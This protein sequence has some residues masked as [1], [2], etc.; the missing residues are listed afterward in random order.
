[1]PDLIKDNLTYKTTL[2]SEADEVIIGGK[3]PL[4]FKPE[5]TFTKWNKENSLTIKPLFDIPNA[6]TSLV[7]NK[8]EYKGD[9]IGWY[10]NPDPD[11]SENLKFGLILY[12][13]P[14]TNVFQFQLEGWE[15]FNFFYQYTPLHDITL[16]P[17]ILISE[18]VDFWYFKKESIA[19]KYWKSFAVYH[20]TK[21]NY[22]IGQTNYMCGKMG[23]ILVPIFKDLNGTTS[24][25]ILTIQNGIY[26]I[27]VN[28]KFLDNAV[29]PVVA[30]DTFGYLTAPTYGNDAG[31][32]NYIVYNDA[33]TVPSGNGTLTSITA[34][35]DGNG[36]STYTA[37]AAL[38][39][40]SVNTQTLVANSSTGE[41]AVPA[42]VGS[43]TTRNTSAATVDSTKT[44]SLAVCPHY[45]GVRTWY[46][47]GSNYAGWK[48]YDFN[49]FPPAT[50]TSTDDR[51]YIWGIYATYTPAGG[52]VPGAG[53]TQHKFIMVS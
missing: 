48:Y 39:T 38:F 50:F 5:I 35:V 31:D 20:K 26:T 23:N 28:Q 4:I 30:N 42:S 44:N 32:S 52:A 21:K 43:G 6:T 11:N 10:A 53:D 1:M 29:Y 41:F 34:Y 45:D 27:I 49:E 2:G 22:V 40:R 3:N 46:D 18:D 33:N 37:K 7:G 19:K 13:K 15:E 16:H 17:E 51:D 14:T 25:V 12:E 8:I 24:Q 9:K 36:T 47:L